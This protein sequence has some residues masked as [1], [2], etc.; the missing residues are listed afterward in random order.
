MENMPQTPH[1]KKYIDLNHLLL[2]GYDGEFCR[3]VIILST[4][5]GMV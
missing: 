3:A 4:N 2:T 5:S 1:A